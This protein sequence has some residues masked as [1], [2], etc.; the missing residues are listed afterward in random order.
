MK[1]LMTTLSAVAVAFGLYASGPLDTGT[2]FEGIEIPEGESSVT[3]D[4]NDDTGELD[5]AGAGYTFWVSNEN[6]TLTVVDCTG[7]GYGIDRPDQ[8]AETN[9]NRYLNVKTTLGNPVTRKVSATGS[10]TEVGSDGYYFDSLV[11]FTAFDSDP[12]ALFADDNGRTVI[13]NGGKIAIWLKENLD[14][15]TDLPTSTNLMITAGYLVNGSVVATNYECIVVGENVNINDGGWHRVTVKA[16]D[17]IY[18]TTPSVPGFIVFVDKKYVASLDASTKGI[19][20]TQLNS[21]YAGFYEAQALFPSAVQSGADKSTITAVDFDGQGDVD[22][23]VFTVSEPYFM[24]DVKVECFTVELGEGVESVTLATYNASEQQIV[25]GCGTF[26]SDLTLVYEPDMY[27]FV[28]GVNY[29]DGYDAAGVATNGYVEVD[30]DS[31]KYMPQEGNTG[32]KIN[33]KRLGATIISYD[34]TFTNTYETVAE[35]IADVEA[36]KV[37]GHAATITLSATVTDGIALNDSLA[38]VTIDLAGNDITNVTGTAAIYLGAGSLTI[39]NSTENIGHV[40]GNGVEY[41]DEAV[42][43]AVG[44]TLAITEGIYD[45]AVYHEGEGS[46]QFTITG[47]IFDK[48]ANDNY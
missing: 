23:L 40:V 43:A 15:V 30:A 7:T 38:N 28:T 13:T 44:T 12:T 10:G 32:I 2:S 25:K 46:A 8:F 34:R 9:Q 20:R 4:I 21:F 24:K 33:A 35:A 27:M 37:P 45:G 36:G 11:R 39:T 16:I 19:D 41:A 14:P 6:A 17:N 3:L 22:D 29:A 48:V 47:G 18:D 5:P 31:D 1:K 42:S 26:T